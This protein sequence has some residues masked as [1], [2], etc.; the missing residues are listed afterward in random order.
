MSTFTPFAPTPQR[1]QVPSAASTADG[2]QPAQSLPGFFAGRFGLIF[3][4][5]A[6]IAS[7]LAIAV[8]FSGPLFVNHAAIPSGMTSV[9]DSTPNDGSAWKTP[10]GC[11]LVAQ[12]LDVSSST[13]EG[14]QFVPSENADLLSHGFYLNITLAPDATVKNAQTPLVVLGN[15]V[16]VA[17][18]Q[19][20][21]YLICTDTCSSYASAGVNISD[22]AS[23]WH[24][25]GTTPNTFTLV[26]QPGGD[27]GQNA[28]VLFINGQQTRMV[29]L[30]VPSGSDLVLA[31]IEPTKGEPGEAIYT[32]VT[33]YSATGP[34]A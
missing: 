25:N 30:S 10:S 13:S 9:Y 14:C 27:H 24:T 15:Y 7:V 19:S 32:H 17:F 2:L 21:Q 18:D 3:G 28:L 23:A 11:S 12:G 5:V 6:V 22:F 29:D 34:G 4:L 20:G 8:A 1:P 16:Y 31:A 26:Y 33:L